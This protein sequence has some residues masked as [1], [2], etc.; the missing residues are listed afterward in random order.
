MA[1]RRS[2]CEPQRGV[3]ISIIE[4]DS[5][6][7][8]RNDTSCPVASLPSN[9]SR[10]RKSKVLPVGS[11]DNLLLGGESIVLVF[12]KGTFMA[13]RKVLVVDDEKCVVELSKDILE[14]AGYKVVPAYKGKEALEKVYTESPEEPGNAE[15]FIGHIGGDDFVGITTPDKVDSICSA[16]I[17]SFDKEIPKFYSP[18]DRT[19]GYI[20][21][22]DRQ[23]KINKFPIMSISIGVVTNTKRR[24]GHKGQ[25]AAVGA[26]IKKYAKSL[27]GSNYVIDRR[28]R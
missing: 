21:G 24:F 23:G 11:S 17:K 25:L 13:R 15:D 9:D 26:E 5:F 10:G 20:T 14:S 19:K 16:I 1:N 8:A 18:K 12:G 4:R 27:K 7:F 6:T 2:R 22:K 3:A 28:A